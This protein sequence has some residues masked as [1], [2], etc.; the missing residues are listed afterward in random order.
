MDNEEINHGRR[1]HPKY[2]IQTTVPD[3]REDIAGPLLAESIGLAVL[4]ASCPH[5]GEWLTRLEQ[6]EAGV[7][8]PL[9]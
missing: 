1:S 2:C 6:L 4:G 7:L 9:P 5:F 3:Y 8:D